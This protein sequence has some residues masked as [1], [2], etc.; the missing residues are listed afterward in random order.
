M[1][2][3]N[4]DLHIHSP[5]SIAVSQ[6]LNLDTMSEM[7][8]KKGIDI[9]G[10]GDILQP[11]WLDY[12]ENNLNKNEDGSYTYNNVFF[13][14][15]TE[16]EDQESIHHL[17]L[18]P[19]F[20]VVKEVQKGLKPHSKNLLGDWGGRPRVNLSPAELVDMLTDWGCLIGPAHAF[21]PF[22]A[23][24]RQSKFDTLEDC[25]QDAAKKVYFVELGLSANTDLADRLKCLEKQTYL[26]NSDAH[27]ENLLGR[28]F[29]KFK[30]ESPSFEELKLAIMRKNDRKILLNV[31]LHPKLGKYYNMFCYKC[32][33]RILFKKSNGKNQGIFNKYSISDNFITYYTDNPDLSKTDYIDKV[34]KD[35]MICPACREKTQK[36]YKI[37]LGVSE[38]IE[39]IS[40][41]TIPKHPDHRPSYVNAVPLIDIIRSVKG[42]KSKTSKTVLKEYERIINELDNESNI[43]IETSINKIKQF[44]KNI[45]DIIKAFRNDEIEY[46]PGGGGTYGQIKF[47][48]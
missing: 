30:I 10:T 34:S 17:V 19:D 46:T 33:R 5:K 22:R 16:I 26:S 44:D 4:A 1:E 6:S 15:Q 13:I 29:N 11:D 47:D 21:T 12:M 42:I 36:N 28:E 20:E 32:R 23:I 48:I 18:F 25:Y 14:L 43:L 37:R 27:S 41:Y 7:C 39:V 45:A 35:K 2:I 8:K 3:Y 38:R 24:F 40:D 31:G 9:L